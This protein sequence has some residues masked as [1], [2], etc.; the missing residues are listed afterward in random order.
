MLFLITRLATASNQWTNTLARIT[1]TPK[2]R[3]R[4]K[5]REKKPKRDEMFLFAR[6]YATI[7]T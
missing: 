7:D 2:E 5:E 6:I 3:K 4:E 1:T